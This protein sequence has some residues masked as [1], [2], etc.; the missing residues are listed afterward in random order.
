MRL[1]LGLHLLGHGLE[2]VDLRGVEILRELD[3][4]APDPP[5]VGQAQRPVAAVLLA[6][7]AADDVALGIGEL[8]ARRAEQAVE[9]V[10]AVVPVVV[11]GNGE[12]LAVGLAH[13]ERPVEGLQQALLVF[14]AR[15]LRVA[16]I[17]AHDQDFA[18][19]QLARRRARR[20]CPGRADRPSCR[21]ARSRRRRRPRSRSRRRRS[22]RARCDLALRRPQALEIAVVVARRQLLVVARIGDRLH[23]A[24][25]GI[26]AEHGRDD[27]A[28]ADAR[29]QP[30][31]VPRH[32]L[33]QAPH[34]ELP[35]RAVFHIACLRSQSPDCRA[36]RPGRP[37]ALPGS[38][39]GLG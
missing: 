17:A 24:L 9:G 35:K 22:R 33:G 8:V 29:Q 34:A 30:R 21:W 16:L 36:A 5:V 2:V 37:S 15:G 3:V 23:Q 4:G 25:V 27:R 20:G 38:L 6:L 13:G 19:P 11:A 14:L 39:A 32:H 26:L 18:V 7:P 1:S 10:E 28:H 31:V 12:Q